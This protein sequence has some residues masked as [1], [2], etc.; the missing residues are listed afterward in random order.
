MTKVTWALALSIFA[1]TGSAF[2][3]DLDQKAPPQQ[4]LTMNQAP[5]PK[6]SDVFGILKH[7]GTACV[8]K[9]A[10]KKCDDDPG[11]CVCRDGLTP[12]SKICECQ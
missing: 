11:T 1:M 9:D 8:A 6:A 3:A 10:G 5:M 7:V 12:G 2:A 4:T